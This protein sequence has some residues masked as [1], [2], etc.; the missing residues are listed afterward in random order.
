[1]DHRQ[2]TVTLRMHTHGIHSLTLRDKCLVTYITM[3]SRVHYNMV[4]LAAFFHRRC[5]YWFTSDGNQVLKS[6]DAVH[7]R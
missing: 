7:T 4:F 1:M 2:G 6:I 5:T 3:C